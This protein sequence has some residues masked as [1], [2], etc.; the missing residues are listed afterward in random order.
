MTEL[1]KMDDTLKNFLLV[2]ILVLTAGVLV[3]LV[4]VSQTTNMTPEGTVTR[5]NGSQAGS[6]EDQFDIQVEYE[7]SVMEMLLTTHTHVMSFSLMLFAIGL[8]FYFN[9][10]V[11]GFWKSFLMI[12]PIISTFIT[13]SSIWAIRFLSKHF[14]YI[15]FFSAALLYGSFFIM[16]GILIYEL[17]YKKASS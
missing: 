15:T 3:G 10:I 5:Y 4:Y 1:Y 13:F 16:A 7:K 9:T 11:T 8:I 14:V 2:F 6:A 17:K 12:E